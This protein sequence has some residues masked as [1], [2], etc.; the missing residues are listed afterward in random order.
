[1]ND[2]ELNEICIRYF[3]LNYDLLY[4]KTMHEQNMALKPEIIVAGSSHAMNGIVEKN[5]TR[6][7]INFSI[8]SQDIYYD[9]VNIHTAL[10]RNKNVKICII[11]IGYYMLYQDLSLSK[12]VGAVV[13]KTYY[14][15]FR[16][17]HHMNIAYAADGFE[18]LEYDR[19]KYTKQEI[20]E[21]STKWI[22]NI[23]SQNPSYYGSV[24]DRQKNNSLCEGVWA[25]LSVEDKERIAIDRTRDHNSLK[26]H[27]HSKYENEKLIQE[28]VKE[29][30]EKG[31][32]PMFVVFPFS[33]SYLNYIN[34]E[35]KEEILQLLEG[36]EDPV[37]YLDMN[38][39]ADYFTDE[40][41]VNPDHMSDCGA[42]KATMLLDQY[43]NLIYERI[44]GEA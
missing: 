8:S 18:Y 27:I 38:D 19:E 32:I 16:D 20:F 43:I 3:L 11:N 28:F 36:L 23:F 9:L 40:D 5:M 33:K 41:F 13:K 30:N 14:P 37:E 17:S 22:S 29:M 6:P 42:E 2:R 26:K 10:E 25:D 7:V 35:Y 4:L 31:I 39:Y 44:T 12:N 15:L 21:I 1:M 24:M 34:M